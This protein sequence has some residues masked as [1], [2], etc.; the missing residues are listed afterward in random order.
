MLG[1]LAEFFVGQNITA[2]LLCC[3]Y[4]Q[5]VRLVTEGIGKLLRPFGKA[6]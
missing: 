4:T 1:I 5:G 2:Y 3:L 6:L